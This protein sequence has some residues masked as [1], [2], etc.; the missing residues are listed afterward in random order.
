MDQARS[1]LSASVFLGAHT[2]SHHR[3]FRGRGD[4]GV[5]AA[6]AT[7][8]AR[9]SGKQMPHDPG[10]RDDGEN[11]E[12]QKHDGI[13]EIHQGLF[14]A[15]RRDV[16][17]RGG[18]FRQNAFLQWLCFYGYR[19]IARGETFGSYAW[20]SSGASYD[21]RGCHGIWKKCCPAWEPCSREWFPG[22]SRPVCKWHFWRQG[23]DS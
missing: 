21:P 7:F 16:K 3:T 22:S 13:A 23:F 14:S 8:L 15:H 6:T 11:A 2:E 20:S 5:A 17:S 12:D 1:P 4:S 18:I 10:A 9:V 19:I